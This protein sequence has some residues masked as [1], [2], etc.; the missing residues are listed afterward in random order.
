[1]KDITGTRID[2]GDRVAYFATPSTVVMIGRVV[3]IL[4]DSN[5]LTIA[6][7]QSSYNGGEMV[8]RPPSTPIIASRRRVVVLP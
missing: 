8:N 1:M 3:E 5:R 2:E 4:D 7:E 6:V